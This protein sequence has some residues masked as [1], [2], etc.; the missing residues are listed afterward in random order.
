MA[1]FPKGG[2]AKDMDDG[3]GDDDGRVFRAWGWA[4]FT[5]C[6]PYS[7]S[8]VT[9]Y[10][11]VVVPTTYGQCELELVRCPAYKARDQA[12]PGQALHQAA[13]KQHPQGPRAWA[14]HGGHGAWQRFE[15]SVQIAAL[16]C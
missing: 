4:L 1:F 10:L 12:R 9:W 6:T 16:L 15:F 5:I 3:A 8:W 2:E 7:F 11:V 14:C 13:E